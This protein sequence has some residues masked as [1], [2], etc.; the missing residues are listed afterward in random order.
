VEGRPLEAE[1]HLDR[2]LAHASGQPDSVIAITHGLRAELRRDAALGQPAADE[3]TAGLAA[4][5]P[6]R[7]FNRWLT[8]LLAAGR[9]YADGPSA[10]LDTLV[11]EAGTE[12]ADVDRREPATLLAIGCYRMLCGELGAA[13]T[14]LSELIASSDSLPPETEVRG[15]QWLALACQL[16]GAWR[17]ADHQAKSAIA[18]VHST[19]ARSSGAPHAISAILAAYRGEQAGAEEQLRYARDL[20][21]SFRPDD[22]V[23]ADVADVT[24][25]HSCA[26]LHLGRPALQRLAKGGDAARKYRALWLPLL[27]ETLV[28]QG[29]E[30]AASAALAELLA[31]AARVPYLRL[32]WFRL[33]GRVQER[34]RDPVAA[35]RLYQAAKELPPECFEVPLQAGLVEHCHGRLLCALG[36]SDQGAALVNEA[37]ARLTSAGA[38]PYA[39]RA[40]AD[41][42]ARRRTLSTEPRHSILTKRERAVARLVAVGLTNQETA[43]RL[44]ITVKTVEYHLAQI[45]SKLGISSRRQLARFASTTS[46][47]DDD[48]P[49]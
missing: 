26:A 44:Y 7:G 43:A 17:E 46:E 24:I 49:G 41:L 34:R 2:A 8:R 23:L 42:S 38:I 6:D 20:A 31:L 25:A 19:G 32:T 13:I 45:Y 11:A 39:R 33:S 36:D 48:F 40:E 1:Y 27:A 9:C 15:R 22:A 3:A 10:A 4:R 47:F 12:R 37:V 21:D 29:E 18:T 35:G 30:P 5:E 14:D 28:E 16:A